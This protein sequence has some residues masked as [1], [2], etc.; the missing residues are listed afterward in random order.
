MAE[1]ED[2][3]GQA[4]EY[5]LGTLDP[6]ERRK[7]ES[8]M[9]GDAGLRELAEDWERL[10]APLAL[11]LEPVSVPAHLRQKIISAVPAAAA[12]GSVVHLER[13]T[14][15]WR[16]LAI[17]AWA[18]A[19]VLAGVLILRPPLAPEAGRFVAVLQSEGQRTAFLAS[20]DLVNGTISVRAVSASLPAGK[21]YEL[22]A[23]GAGREKAQSLGVLK[24]DFRIAAGKLGRL[25]RPALSETVFAISLEPEGGSPTG[26]PTGP[27]L[28]TGKLVATE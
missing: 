8:E 28:F 1:L 9:A 17:G 5:A 16:G 6:G 7:F 14:R 13:R 15:L 20:V 26:Q 11:A 4:A 10:L 23:L 27:V 21:S 18:A 25:E 2:R 19:A 12:P 24:A 22:W 3:E